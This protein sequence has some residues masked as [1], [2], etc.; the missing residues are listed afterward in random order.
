M[1]TVM[2]PGEHTVTVDAGDVEYAASSPQTWARWSQDYAA[3]LAGQYPHEDAGARACCSHHATYASEATTWSG[4]WHSGVAC[5]TLW[6]EDPRTAGLGLYLPYVGYQTQWSVPDLALQMAWYDVRCTQCTRKY[7][8]V[9]FWRLAAASPSWIAA[10]QSVLPTEY[11]SLAT[12]STA[13]ACTAITARVTFEAHD[14][15]GTVPLTVSVIRRTDA[16]ADL[17]ISP[18]E[19]PGSIVDSMLISTGG[20]TAEVDFDEILTDTGYWLFRA[21]NTDVD[22]GYKPGSYP[23]TETERCI[24]SIWGSTMTATFSG[25][26]TYPALSIAG[27]PPLHATQRRGGTDAHAAHAMGADTRQSRKYARG[28]L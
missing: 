21:D 5:P 4:G 6:A 27:V 23:G 22:L 1:P 19:M 8:P 17:W 25:T 20:E 3:Y 2:V 7:A 10:A 15:T 13:I 16:G 12:T 14:F 11:A 9:D 18:G 26:V 28:P 24:A